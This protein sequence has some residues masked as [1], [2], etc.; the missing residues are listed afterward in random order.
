MSG[1]AVPHVVAPHKG[2][3]AGKRRGD[4]LTVDRSFHTA[5]PVEHDAIVIAG[6][7][8]L[9]TNASAIEW[10]RI[11]YR[12][13]KPIAVWGDG[14]ELLAAASVP[15][16][17][18]GVIMSDKSGKRFVADLTAAMA[19]HRVWDRLAPHPTRDLQETTS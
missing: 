2:S 17:A 13:L 1:G 18:P 6:G 10:V 16:D 5:S 3:L 7:G 14:A 19:L 9:A 12:H 4:E 8:G 15:T 11:A